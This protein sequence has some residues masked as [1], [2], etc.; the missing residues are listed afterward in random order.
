[1][2]VDKFSERLTTILQ[3]S[4]EDEEI[5]VHVLYRKNLSEQSKIALFQQLT[6][7][8]GKEGIKEIMHRSSMLICSMN[9]KAVRSLAN[10]TE[11]DW[12][13]LESQAPI[14]ELLD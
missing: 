8:I 14:E 5:K 10:Q 13:D 2:K 3:A 4:P 12:I 7:I 1:M 11:I 9:V 6:N